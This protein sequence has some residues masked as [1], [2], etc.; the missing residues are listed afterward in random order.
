MKPPSLPPE[1]VSHLGRQSFVLTDVLGSGLC[2]SVY[3]AEQPTL[4]RK[5]AV[6]FFDSAFVRSDQAMHKRFI[7]EAKLLARFQHPN[8]PYVL[9]EGVVD[10][11]HGKAPY[12]VME[13]VSGRTL[14]DLLIEKGK[15]DRGIAVEIAVQ[16]LDALS[17]AH[18]NQIVHRDVKPTN[19]MIDSRMRCF[20]ID[21]S[22]GVSFDSQPGVTRAT[23]RG[24]FLGSPPYASPEQMLDAATVDGRSDIYSVGVMLVELLTGKPETANFGKTLASLPRGMIDAVEKACASSPGDRH[25]TADDF[26]RAIGNRN[27]TAPPTLSPAL[28][29]CSNV[30]CS[31]ANWSSRGYYRGPRVIPDSTGSF[32]TSCGGSLA[33]LCKNC[34]API[35]ET[36]YCGSC[37]SENFR[38]PECRTCG[39]WLTKEFMDSLGQSGCAKCKDKKPVIRRTAP[40]TAPS[41]DDDIPF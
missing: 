28:A 4:N 39:S 32:C 24:E 41:T 36:P 16:I 8:I 5:V 37:G 20:L 13:Y 38:V 11:A 21:F 27:H 25:R 12:F 22:I 15:L 29:I 30:K 14:G 26:I 19:V 6:K 7:R 1:Y 10:A 35:S 9:T 40:Q 18:I 17:Y 2:G 3:L 23:T 34:G 33:Y 31:G